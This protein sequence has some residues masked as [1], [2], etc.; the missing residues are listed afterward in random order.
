MKNLKQRIA[1][2]GVILPGNI[3]KVDSFIN[4]QIDVKLLNEMGVEFKERFKNVKV[5][6]ILTIE[7]SGIAIAVITAQYFDV[8]V[9]FAKKSEA[10]NLDK[11]AYTSDVYS[12]TKD[13]TFPVKVAKE[14]LLE[15]ENI[16]IIDD[17]LANGKAIE[18][19]IDIID[20]AHSHCVGV[21]IAIEKGF[22]SGGKK[23]REAGVKVES[24]AIIESI[25]GNQI[26][27]R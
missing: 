19:L 2:D 4:H 27:F 16:L 9:V 18:G 26:L 23:L 15:N 20:Q 24:L 25:E 14:Y 12:Y 17:F 1:K 5:D 6:K 11:N 13:K 21:G 10:R 7:A 3:V 8:P 22:Q